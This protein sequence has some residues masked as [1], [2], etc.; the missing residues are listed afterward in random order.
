MPD[1][2]VR[3]R[4]ISSLEGKVNKLDNKLNDVQEKLGAADAKIK[5]IG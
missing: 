3:W 5:R 2:A 4:D 1:D